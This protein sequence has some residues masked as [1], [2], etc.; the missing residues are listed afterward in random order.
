[1]SGLKEQID[2]LNTSNILDIEGDADKGA[3]DAFA[4]KA[5]QLNLGL[6]DQVTILQ[7][8]GLDSDAI[9]TRV[10]DILEEVTADFGIAFVQAGGSI[11]EA[12]G[13][14][15]E[16]QEMINSSDNPIALAN[17][18]IGLL[19]TALS[20][21]SAASYAPT[22]TLNIVGMEALDS[23]VEKAKFLIGAD[24]ASLSALGAFGPSTAD[25]IPAA[26]RRRK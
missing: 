20:E 13:K 25:T 24:V 9:N 11:D 18:E 7:A 14:M 15:A 6:E 10:K 17:G 19:G 8:T 16:F 21:L 4:G 22:I 12:L 26:D 3:I 1:M 2:N 23:V 5:S